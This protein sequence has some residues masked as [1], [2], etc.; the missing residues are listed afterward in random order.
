MIP[1]TRNPVNLVEYW[2]IS[3]CNVK[4][5]IVAKSMA[6]RLQLIMPHIIYEAQS[7]FIKDHLI[8]NNVMGAVEMFHWMRK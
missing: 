8:T 1:K 4:Y 5:K 7:A 6:N 3:L 2:P